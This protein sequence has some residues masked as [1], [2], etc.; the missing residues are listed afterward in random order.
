MNLLGCSFNHFVFIVVFLTTPKVGNASDA[1]EIADNTRKGYLVT[2]LSNVAQ[3]WVDSGRQV[4]EFQ[5]GMDEGG[6]KWMAQERAQMILT[7][8]GRDL[9]FSHRLLSKLNTFD[10]WG[11]VDTHLVACL[12]DAMTRNEDSAGEIW[13]LLPADIR[14]KVLRR[15]LPFSETLMAKIAPEVGS[16]IGL[17]DDYLSDRT[18]PYL[19]STFYGLLTVAKTSPSLAEKV[20]KRGLQATEVDRENSANAHLLAAFYRELP[21]QRRMLFE[22]VEHKIDELKTLVEAIAEEEGLPMSKDEKFSA[23][24]NEFTAGVKKRLQDE[25]MK[26]KSND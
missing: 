17:M 15:S 1:S 20:V 25:E 23:L 11:L 21:S 3:D 16:E 7:T 24:V 10:G 13:A 22:K 14:R 4:T 26:A 8:I 5:K 12:V 9:P 6:V 19:R 18:D 2:A